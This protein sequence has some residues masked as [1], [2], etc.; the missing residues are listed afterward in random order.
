LCT[1]TSGR[2]ATWRSAST[3]A[4]LWLHEWPVCRS[5][6]PCRQCD[7]HCRR[8]RQRCFPARLAAFS[9]L[10]AAPPRASISL[11]SHLQTASPTLL[12]F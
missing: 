6:L 3:G 7:R 9:A 12:S 5:P 4:W 8:W 2:A 10:F 11:P 1:T